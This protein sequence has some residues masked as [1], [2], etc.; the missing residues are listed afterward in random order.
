MS[1][2]ETRRK[3]D[4]CRER[5]HTH[6]HTHSLPAHSDAR[7]HAPDAVAVKAITMIQARLWETA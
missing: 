3:T 1:A 2:R 6:T 5:T 7:A 4:I